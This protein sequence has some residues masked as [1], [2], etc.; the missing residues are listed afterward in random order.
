MSHPKRVYSIDFFIE[1]I[2]GY[3]SDAEQ[4]LVW[5]YVSYLRK[6]LKVLHAD[7]KIKAYRNAGY[8]LEPCDD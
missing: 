1:K 7:V 8:S 5:T 6:K 3:E 2:W 4:S